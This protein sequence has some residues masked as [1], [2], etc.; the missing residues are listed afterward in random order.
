M[1]SVPLNNGQ[2]FD[3]FNLSKINFKQVNFSEFKI[4]YR[5]I[6][7]TEVPISKP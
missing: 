7:P 2:D 3:N 5:Y 6:V 4:Q 1:C